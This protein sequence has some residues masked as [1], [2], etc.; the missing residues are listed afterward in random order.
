MS[1][2][3]RSLLRKQSVL[4]RFLA[5]S[6]CFT[7]DKGSKNGSYA[8]DCSDQACILPSIFQGRYIAYGDLDELYDAT[9]SKTY[10][11]ALETISL[12]M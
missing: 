10:E 11:D 12:H 4:A 9:A 5:Q 1:C 7:S 2:V 6:G 8:P 3:L